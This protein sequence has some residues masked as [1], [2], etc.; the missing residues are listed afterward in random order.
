MVSVLIIAHNEEKNIKKCI[1]SIISQSEKPD[2]IVLVAHNC[3]DN[4]IK[5]AT[6]YKNIKIVEF[7]GPQGILFARIKG[8]NETSGDIIACIDGDSYASRDWLKKINKKFQEN[9]S[10]SAV[11]GMVWFYNGI[12]A[13]LWSISFF[14]FD[15]FF[16]PTYRFYFWGTNFACKKSDYDSI[17]GLE[18]LVEL[19]KTLKLNFWAEDLYLSLA[20]SKKGSVVFCPPAY[21]WSDS[22]EIASENRS[23]KQNE[24]R[25]SL[26]RYFKYIK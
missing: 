2:E 26:L 1:D 15:R 7:N 5:I 10:I 22:K 4:T 18:P 19:K 8:F 3:S 12:L 23:K 6:E 21:V 24:D 14:F 25:F 11:G 9:A 13:N 20:L 16:R 17:L